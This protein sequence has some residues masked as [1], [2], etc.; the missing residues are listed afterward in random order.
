MTSSSRPSAIRRESQSRVER[1]TRERKTLTEKAQKLREISDL[2]SPSALL[3]FSLFSFWFFWSLLPQTEE[4][5]Q[6][7]HPTDVSHHHQSQA[8]STFGFLHNEKRSRALSL[9]L[10]LS[11]HNTHKNTMQSAASAATTTHRASSS[12]FY[13]GEK[14]ATKSGFSSSKM[15]TKR[16]KMNR[17]QHQI[18]KAVQGEV[19]I[20]VDKPL[21]VTLKARGGGIPGVCI[22]RVAGNGAKA[23]LKSGDVVMYHSSFFG[24]ELW[25][26]DQLGFSRSAINACPNTVDFIIVRGPGE[27]EFDVKRLPKRPAPPKFGRKMSAAQ[28]ERASH[29]C[30]DC[31]FVY[32]LPTPFADQDKEYSCPQCSAPRSRFAKYDPE[33]GRAV[34]GGLSTP[35]V[36]TAAT[37]VGLAGI[38]YYV[39]QIL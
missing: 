22:D 32:A 39:A 1:E 17:R 36:T 7:K 30:V 21:G 23:G 13:R 37:V 29:I 20:S 15:M 34:G 19:L 8:L 38:A 10:F 16:N 18:I 35:L 2:F 24:D 4:S 6:K 12:Q 5:R 9:S 26:A 3:S 11:P 31:G 28:A 33:T 25:P 27:K 14:T